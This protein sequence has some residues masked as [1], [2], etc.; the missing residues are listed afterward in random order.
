MDLVILPTIDTS[1]EHEIETPHASPT[2]VY[3]TTINDQ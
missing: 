3:A 2:D 1:I